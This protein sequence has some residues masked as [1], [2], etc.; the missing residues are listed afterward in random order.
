MLLAL[1]WNNANTLHIAKYSNVATL[2]N[3]LSPMLITGGALMFLAMTVMATY[4][5]ITAAGSAEKI[6]K[7]QKIFFFAIVGL[8]IVIFSYT[9]VRLLGYLL[10][11]ENE[12]KPL[13]F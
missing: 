13:G 8:V 10:N 11:I 5:I 12:L 6:A 9:G 4:N 3:I 1:N 7:A 2:V